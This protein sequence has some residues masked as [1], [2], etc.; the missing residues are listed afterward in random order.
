MIVLPDA[1]P[2]VAQQIAERI[3]ATMEATPFQ[4]SVDPGELPCTM[5]FGVATYKEGDTLDSLLKRADDGLYDAKE[6][7]RNK[8]VFKE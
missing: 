5:S 4:I 3:R 7:G 8:V 2:L 1:P 6:S